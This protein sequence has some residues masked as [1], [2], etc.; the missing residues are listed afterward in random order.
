[1]LIAMLVTIFGDTQWLE[2]LATLGATTI[3]DVSWLNE[4]DLMRLG[5]T[6][7]WARKLLAA[8][9]QW[10][11]QQAEVGEA[12]YRTRGEVVD[13]EAAQRLPN[14]HEKR[15][16]MDLLEQ[17]E[18]KVLHHLCM[19]ELL[20][21]TT[22]LIMTGIVNG[23]VAAAQTI[24][25]SKSVQSAI[26]AE[27]ATVRA[28]SMLAHGK[29]KKHLMKA[30]RWL[31]DCVVIRVQLLVPITSRPMFVKAIEDAYGGH[32]GDRRNLK[33]QMCHTHSQTVCTLFSYAF[34]SNSRVENAARR[35]GKRGP[36]ARDAVR[37]MAV[38]E[39]VITP[40]PGLELG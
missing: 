38:V 32:E 4:G 22:V 34:T 33:A 28:L 3:E 9:L 37:N 40:P 6:V 1:M 15:L 21:T 29:P 14:A 31:R 10:L 19:A 16:L 18:L 24:L 36:R 13:A 25:P 8:V 35:H 23:I 12:G 20:V 7:V 2:P 17:K 5:M 11:F 26:E 39:E 27:N 30:Q